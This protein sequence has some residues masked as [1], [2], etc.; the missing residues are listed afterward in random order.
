MSDTPETDASQFGTGR[1]SVDFARKLERERDEWRIKFVKLER[2]AILQNAVAV[3]YMEKRDQWRE[4]AERLAA[5]VVPVP[6]DMA[7]H[8]AC[9]AA[10]AEFDRLKEASK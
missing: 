5:F 3:D 4:C 7:D 8:A 9:A 6:A 1:V 2:S 10:L